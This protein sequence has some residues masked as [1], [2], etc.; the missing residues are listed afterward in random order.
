MP[1]VRHRPSRA[2]AV[3]AAAFAFTPAHADYIATPEEIRALRAKFASSPPTASDYA[4]TPY[5][6]A[7][8]DAECSARATAPRKDVA[9][10]YC[11]HTRDPEERVRAYMK[12]E[13]RPRNGVRVDVGEGEVKVD[14]VVRIPKATVIT[15]WTYPAVMA[16][17]ASFPASPPSAAELIAPLPSD[18][19]YDKECSATKSLEARRN[20]QRWRQVWCYVVDAPVGTVAQS[21]D[22][23]FRFT[24]KRGVQ[25]ELVAVSTSPPL[26][27]VQYWLTTA[28]AESAAP[29]AQPP[30]PQPPPQSASTPGPQPAQTATPQ[31]AATPGEPPPPARPAASGADAASQTLDAVNRLR[32][33]FGR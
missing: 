20:P 21:F 18:A 23:D 17:H 12:A 2:L 6:G 13:G 26:T 19:R 24:R 29:A 31:P 8:F 28:A 3:L 32:G 14:G 7:I 10:V 11:F 25:V 22:S 5:P 27:Q 16:F 15:Y 4:A 1:P 9:T 33:L 30:Q